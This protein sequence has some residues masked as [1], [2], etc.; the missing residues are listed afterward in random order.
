MRQRSQMKLRSRLH[1]RDGEDLDLDSADDR[2][3]KNHDDDEEPS[4]KADSTNELSSMRVSDVD[5]KSAEDFDNSE[6][7]RPRDQESG[8]YKKNGG[9]QLMA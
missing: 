7:Q 8:P 2:G 3:S 6:D 4:K 5:I 1:L 9:K